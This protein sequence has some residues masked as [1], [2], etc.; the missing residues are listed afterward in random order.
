M[1]NE[2]ADRRHS[3]GG[4]WIGRKTKEA[5]G[6]GGLNMFISAAIFSAICV[7]PPLW[8]IGMFGLSGIASYAIGARGGAGKKGH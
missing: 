1:A 8:L 5:L 2:S 6:V 7:N 3:K 4:E